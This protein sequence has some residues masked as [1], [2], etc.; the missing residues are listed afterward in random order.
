VREK[1]V[2]Y[3]RYDFFLEVGGAGSPTAGSTTKD[4]NAK[5]NLVF[6]CA[7]RR[8]TRKSLYIISGDAV[9]FDKK[10]RNYVAKCK[11]NLSKNDFTVLTAP[12]WCEAPEQGATKGKT[13]KP[14]QELA[15]VA[16]TPSTKYIP[17]QM[18]VVL[19][20]NASDDAWLLQRLQR[21][22]CI[23]TPVLQNTPPQWNTK[24]NA[25]EVDFGGRVVQASGKNLQLQD[26]RGSNKPVV[27][28]FGKVDDSTYVL[29]FCYPLS[30]VQAFSIALAAFNAL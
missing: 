17:S 16:F 29:D 23:N 13:K 26:T 8:P 11:K 19:T 25:Y 6:M 1:K 2:L 4:S 9:D 14:R 22:D 3:T 18:Q 15:A 20:D 21:G 27:L 5:P 10:G 12:S 30:P 28:T 7:A 24:T